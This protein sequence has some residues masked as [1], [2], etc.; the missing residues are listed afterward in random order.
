MRL[1]VCLELC[2]VPFLGQALARPGVSGPAARPHSLNRLSMRSN[3]G[4]SKSSCKASAD[5]TVNAPKQ[6]IFQ[7]L[8]DR[9]YADVTAFLHAQDE[10]NLTAVV[11]ST[12]YV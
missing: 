5:V 2:L 10:L 1:V 4:G 7:T 12:A 3:N 6:N 9:E 11:N 8:T